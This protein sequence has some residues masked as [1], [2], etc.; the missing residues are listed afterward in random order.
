MFGTWNIFDHLWHFSGRGCKEDVLDLIAP[1][2]FTL[3]LL[4]LQGKPH[5]TFLVRKATPGTAHSHTLSIVNHGVVTHCKIYE[6]ADRG[7]FGFAE[8]YHIYPTLLS[9]VLHYSQESLEQFNPSL[10]TKLSFPVF[11]WRKNSSA[12]AA[13]AALAISEE[14][15]GGG[16]GTAGLEGL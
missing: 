14:G 5:G 11:Q 10:K 7:L 15:E 6:T 13:A 1:L 3:T 12:A 8:P 16:G 4:K 2:A 9:L